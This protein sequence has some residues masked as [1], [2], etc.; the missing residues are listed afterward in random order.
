[1]EDKKDSNITLFTD[2][3]T[4]SKEYIDKY[5]LQNIIKENNI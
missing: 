5:N 1:M 4:K 2:V 3:L